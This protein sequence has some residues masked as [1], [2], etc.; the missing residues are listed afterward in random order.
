MILGLDVSTS[1]TGWCILSDDRKLV[2]MGFIPLA[3]EK[4]LFSKAQKVHD[5]LSLINIKY[6]VTKIFIEKNL[7]AFRPGLSSAATLL[8]L[9]QFNGIVSY[10]C[11]CEFSLDPEFINVN[12][13][14][15]SLG[16]KIIRKSN[17]GKPTK[18]QVLDWVSSQID[19]TNYVWPVKILKG[20]PRKGQT[21]LE[22]GC[23]DMADAY[24]IA[25][26]GLMI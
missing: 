15:K 25:R 8:T 20:G 26:S 5:A 18:H 19:D 24:V 12:S 6:P 17:G 3:K 14:R 1:C 11:H 22:P 9:A 13:A 23:Y 10:L 4:G 16:I 2:K 21:V 7:Q